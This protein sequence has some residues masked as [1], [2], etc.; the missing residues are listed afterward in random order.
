MVKNPTTIKEILLRQSSMAIS[1]QVFATSLLD[2]S[3]VNFH[4]AV[5]DESEMIRTQRGSITDQ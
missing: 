3:A 5:V 2:V 4:R 1:R